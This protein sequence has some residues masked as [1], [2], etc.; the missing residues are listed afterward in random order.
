M[1]QPENEVLDRCHDE[2]SL[3]LEDKSPCSQEEVTGNQEA[4][5]PE[6]RAV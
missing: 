2:Q 4:V 5:K 1:K 3:A 6:S